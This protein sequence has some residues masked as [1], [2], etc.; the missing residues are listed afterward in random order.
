M[1]LVE[2]RAPRYALRVDGAA[3][4]D[5]G[6]SYLDY[7]LIAYYAASRTS[8]DVMALV[9]IERPTR[10]VV[11][12]MAAAVGAAGP[13]SMFVFSDSP[14]RD[15]E[16][17]SLSRDDL[18]NL[19][20]EMSG[21]GSIEVS[22]AMAILGCPFYGAEELST[23]AAA[24]EGRRSSPR[25]FVQ[26]SRAVELSAPRTAAAIGRSGATLLRCACY[27]L[28]PADEWLNASTVYTDSMK[29]VHYMRKRGVNAYLR[30]AAEILKGFT[31]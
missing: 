16:V 29:A 5:G 18:V 14:P 21:S 19:K 22:G 7:Q 1:H 17:E 24:L 13:S 12:L 4:K 11:K 31:S 8:A 2:N 9:G 6:P 26:T 10:S 3:L 15:A 30:S 28:S 20:R 27:P 25:L 23:V